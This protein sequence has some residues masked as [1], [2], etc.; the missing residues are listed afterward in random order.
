[1][2]SFFEVTVETSGDD[3]FWGPSSSASSKFTSPQTVII[4][5]KSTINSPHSMYTY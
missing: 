3:I 4:N 2:S 1:M 5:V